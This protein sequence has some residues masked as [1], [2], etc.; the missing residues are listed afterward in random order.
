MQT[1]EPR[2]R[3]RSLSEQEV[4]TA[5]AD[6]SPKNPI[7]REVTRL[8][9]CYRD[10]FEDEDGKSAHITE[11]ALN[12]MFDSPIEVV[13]VEIAA[14]AHDENESKRVGDKISPEL[15]GMI[16]RAIFGKQWQTPLGETLGINDRT[17][18]RW[19]VSGAPVRIAKELHEIVSDKEESVH[20]ARILLAE[21]VLKRPKLRLVEN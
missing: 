19:V 10:F 5:L 9:D 14:T 12:V 4:R 13:A 15:L 16:G 8:A 7:K 11:R 20:M 3:F 1:I 6:K 18:R 2:K 17:M 21:T